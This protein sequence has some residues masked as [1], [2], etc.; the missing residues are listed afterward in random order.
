[1]DGVIE[2]M[3]EMINDLHLR[4][5]VQNASS[6]QCACVESLQNTVPWMTELFREEMAAP[7]AKKLPCNHIFHKNCLRSLTM[8][9]SEVDKKQ[10]T[11]HHNFEKKSDNVGN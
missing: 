9:H 2:V 11:S 1:M 7:T 3:S 10:L 6:S 8:C 4:G 5:V